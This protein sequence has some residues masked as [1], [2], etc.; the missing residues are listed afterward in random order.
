M[1]CSSAG[2]KEG[3]FSTDFVAWRATEGFPFAKDSDHHLPIANSHFR[4]VATKGAHVWWDVTPRGLG[5]YLTIKT[6]GQCIWVA[7]PRPSA[8]NGNVLCPSDYD[9][10]GNT[11]LFDVDIYN[12][13][14][15][16]NTYWVVEQ[17]YLGPGMTMYARISS[18][19]C[20]GIRLS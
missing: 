11:H 13:S 4:H 6:G 12:D 5:R 8:E 20:C 14:S 18:L 3:P 16:E 2:W 9:I 1:P 10:M 7:R 17:I 15:P 19:A